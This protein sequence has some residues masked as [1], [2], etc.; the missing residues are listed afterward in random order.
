VPP[1]TAEPL[2]RV[3]PDSVRWLWPRFLPRGK[4]TLL[5]GDS[6]VGKS[7]LTVDLAA[8][9]SGGG[10]LPTGEPVE[11][12]HVVLLLNAEDAAA[13]TTRPRATAAGADLNRLH[14]VSS[15]NPPHLPECLPDLERL[16]RE[17]NADLLVIDP[18]MAFLPPKV[19]ANLDQCVRTALTPLAALAERT[20]CGVLMVRH[21]RKGASDKAIRRGQGS[22]GIVGAARTG[23][24]A[25]PHPA[26]PTLRI[27]AVTKTNITDPPPSLGYRIA[28]GPTDLPV[29]EWTGVVDLSAD[30][31]GG[32]PPR[33]PAGLKP[34]DRAGMWLHAELRNGPRRAT[35]LF[36]AAAEAGIPEKT[37]KRAKEMMQVQSHQVRQK[38]R[39]EWYWYDPDA[40]W[41]ANAPFR[42][43][44]QL[45]DLPPL[46][47]LGE[48]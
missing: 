9:L 20:D 25:G 15:E 24:L 48:M 23:W 27:L 43:P 34:R 16:I 6:G 46:P 1:L 5:D 17:T 2:S 38:G 39:A 33:P 42:R 18:L 36:T 19:A 13:D 47:P 28:R 44:F 7:L 41:P 45:S 14:V 10:P 11:R 3:R 4:L 12:P 31:V 40:P 22:M 37:L 30:V 26:D 32:K 8:R 29:V 21:L 35:E